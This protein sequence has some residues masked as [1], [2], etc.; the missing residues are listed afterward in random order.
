MHNRRFASS[1]SHPS[2]RRC[3]QRTVEDQ[4]RQLRHLCETRCQRR[5][6]IVYE[7]IAC[8]HRRPSARPSQNPTNRY[9]LAHNCPSL[10]H[11]T[12]S[13]HSRRSQ[14][15][16]HSAAA[17]DARSVPVR[18]SEVSCVILKR[19][20]ASDAAPAALIRLSARTTAPR[21]APRKPPPSATGPA[22]NRPGPQHATSS[23]HCRRPA[24]G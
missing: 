6:P 4:R 9:S 14:A 19:L 23:T 22:R 8:T 15:P 12:A 13:T 21:L 24:Y 5:C 17:A 10:Q 11:A 1:R 3:T 18:F 20:G 16:A 2:C 7:G